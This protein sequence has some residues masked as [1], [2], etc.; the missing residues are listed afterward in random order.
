[1]TTTGDADG[2][3]QE[4]VLQAVE[5]LALLLT[6]GGMPR[7]PA[8]V[9]AYLLIS[10]D[11]GLTAGEMTARLR[12]SPA[13]VSGAVRY[14]VQTGLLVRERLPGARSDHYRLHNDLWYETYLQRLDLLRRWEEL[15][16]ET[17]DLIGAERAGRSLRET[18]AFLAFLQD[19]FVGMIERWR[20]HK[21]SLNLPGPR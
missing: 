21:R 11:D 15:L 20:E 10:E 16:A 9:F 2:A 1:M 4:V 3:E 14:L 12:V 5:R 19:E 13:A 8:R 17:M 7:M 18:R 6:E